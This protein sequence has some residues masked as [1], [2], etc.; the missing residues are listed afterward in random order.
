MQPE[1]RDLWMPTAGTA[2]N[3]AVVAIERRYEG[4]AHKVAQSLWGAGQMMFNKYMLVV[5]MPRPTCAIRM[6]WRGS[7]ATST[8]CAT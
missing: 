5:P 6:H 3:L 4:Q 1:V 8:R 7:C 2:H